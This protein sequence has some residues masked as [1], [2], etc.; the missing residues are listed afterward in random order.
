MEIELAIRPSRKL[1]FGD[2][3]EVWRYRDLLS[4]LVWRDFIAK[5]KQTVLGPIWFL[6]QPLLP[7]VVFTLVF[8]KVAGMSTDGL[9]QFLFFLCNQI[10]WGYFSSNFTS[11]SNSL[12]G[13]LHIFSKVYFPRLVPALASLVSNC[14]SLAIQFALFFAFYLYFKFA[15]PAGAQLVPTWK[16]VFVP[17][18]V[19]LAA[20]QGLGFGF[21]MAAV[22]AKYRDL[23]QV[24]GVLVQ[25]WMYGSAVIFP[26]SQIPEKYQPLVS[27]NPITFLT[28]SFRVCL[29]GEGTVSWTAGIY[30]VGVSVVVLLVGL[31]VFDRI[32][33]KFVDVA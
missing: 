13:N 1:S 21:L 19:V 26:L 5:Y 30:S 22:T 14:L 2:L 18:L 10:A 25:L 29:L 11:V 7:T 33:R 6:L 9:P 23:Q 4:L 27:L 20:V 24:A 15:T 8:G 16:I 3:P 28:E 31:V 12:L 17:L 32:S